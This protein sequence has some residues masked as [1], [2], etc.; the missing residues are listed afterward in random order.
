MK[1]FFMFLPVLFFSVAAS[2]QPYFP[3]STIPDSMRKN[4]DAVTREEYIKFTIKDLNSAR[5]DVHEVVTIMNESG[6]GYLD[7][8]YHSSK[9]ATLDNAEMKV[10]DA[11]GNKKSTFS[12]KD[13]N[14]LNYGEGLVPEG[15][16]TYFSVNAPAYPITIETNYTVK[17]NGLFSYPG[18]YFQTPYHAV[19]KAV[20]E[21]EAPANLSFRYKLLNCN[22]QPVITKGNDREVYHWEVKNLP[23]YKS[24]R[25]TGG[26]DYFVPQVLLGPNKFQLED[27]EGDMTNWKNFGSWLNRLYEKTNEL[28]DD[29]KNFYRDLVKNAPTENEK[30]KLLYTYLQNN[31]R[32]VSIQLGIGGWRPFPAGFVDEKK[33]GDCKALSNYLKSALDAVGIRSNLVVIYRDYQPKI[34]DGQFPVNEF[35]HVILSVPKEKDTLWLECTSNSLPFAELDE[36]TLSR[37]ALMLT[38]NGG[39]L[40]NTPSSNYRHNETVFVTEIKVDE[41]GGAAVTMQSNSYGEPRSNLQTGFHE[42]KEDD[43]KKAF[44]RHTEWKQPDR[45]ELAVSE[46]MKNPYQLS[47]KMEYENIASFKAG[48]KL[49]LEPRL[50]HFFDED[51]PDNAK[52]LNDYYFDYPYQ[53]TDTTIYLLP[54]GYMPESLPK[55]KNIQYPF[56][57]YTSSCTWDEASHKL[58]CVAYVAVKE[59]VVKAADYSKLLDFKSQVQTD[60]NE[61]IVVKRG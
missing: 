37:T 14:S 60:A 7:F 27:Y 5:Y 59:R 1:Q 52:R 48:S 23:A 2:A 24:E 41:E 46:K 38:E 19:E 49:F 3:V 25:H 26:A 44:I 61:K 51:I 12:K 18:N 54:A 29:R 31:M 17:F 9:F 39:V 13:M 35:N 15:K 30:I 8:S 22:Y 40:V 6:N 55:N 28:R 36:S 57:S 11:A 4:A 50:Y 34:V 10:Y 43:K 47:A 16:M 20:F 42:L 56:A 58:T 53:Q 45:F 33:Y 32:Y 21:V